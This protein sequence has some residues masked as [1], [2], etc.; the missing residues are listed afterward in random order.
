M[1]NRR[2]TLPQ[3]RLQDDFNRA[4]KPANDNPSPLDDLELPRWNLSALYSS[5]DAP[6]LKADLARIDTLCDDFAETYEGTLEWLSGS[7]LGKAVMVYEQIEQL[8][9]KISCY[10][11]LMESDNVGNFA[12][13]G[14][15]N[16]WF[17][18]NGGKIG[19]FEAELAE[20]K[21]QILIPKLAA[22]ELAA[23]APWL[24]AMRARSGQSF[25]EHVG[26][27]SAD[28]ATTSR[29]GWGRFYHETINALR[30]EWRGEKLSLDDLAE[31]LADSKM[32]LQDRAAGRQ[33][34]ADALKA[35]SARIALCY[36]AMIRDDMIDNDLSGE[37]RPDAPV[38]RANRTADEIVDTMFDTI[39]ASY[40]RLS[41][42][43]YE[44][45]AQQHGQEVL[46]RA[47]VGM[48][49]P[50][51]EGASS[52]YSFGEAQRLV[53][54]AFRKFSP[55]FAR[56]AEKVFT[57]GHIDAEPR[58]G[59]E[60]GAFALPTGPG[61]VPYVMLSF[62]GSAGDVAA[63]LGHELGHSVHQQLSEK[64]CGF[65]M[66]DVPTPVAETASIFAEML[67]FEE[68]LKGEKDPAVRKK[69]LVDRVENM[70]GNGLQQ[71]AYYDF[72]K[73]VHNARRDGELDAEAISDIW[74]ETQREYYGPSIETDDYDRYYWMTVPHFF[75][76]PFYVSSYAFA[77]Q[78]VS[79]L[80]QSYKAAEAE[81]KEA[82]AEFIENY[83][84]LLEAG[85]TKN[86]YEMFQ[87]F[88]LDPES[89]EF[90]E[91]GLSLNAKYLDELIKLDAAPAAPAAKKGKTPRS[92]K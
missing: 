59:K 81:G 39:K 65:F 75:D 21:E 12:K 10:I 41:H 1:K 22:P 14:D 48:T 76:T 33:A 7:D 72:E 44:W 27:L 85:L 70:L 56:L 24:A 92:G 68:L 19:F 8:R 37:K 54:R 34:M 52:E 78:V 35:Q 86:L 88:D 83:I 62:T 50:G 23:Y 5:P 28:F 36:N 11:V 66:S 53:L 57:V 20:M 26:G 17:Q 38:N 64:A 51:L 6:E 40:A 2:T 25:P 61:D 30:V 43:F 63:T 79:G 16:K 87:P 60:G 49:L 46:P 3:K 47:Q 13:L 69:L 91:N 42:R 4:R 90:W 18:E 74:I 32:T 80:Y 82:R 73:R 55:K 84:E 89:R 67:V 31:E 77:Q 58:E 9:H 15:L 45:K 71:L 29:E